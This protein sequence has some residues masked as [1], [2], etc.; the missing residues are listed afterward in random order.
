MSSPDVQRALLDKRAWPGD[1][2]SLAVGIEVSATVE[3]AEDGAAELEDGTTV[4]LGLEENGFAS[5]ES[6]VLSMAIWYEFPDLC[7]V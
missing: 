5:S 6:L 4:G 7:R 3:L 2:A 1:W